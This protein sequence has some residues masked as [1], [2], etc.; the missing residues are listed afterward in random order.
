MPPVRME[1]FSPLDLGD[2]LRRMSAGG[3]QSCP[4]GGVTHGFLNVEGRLRNL[5]TPAGGSL[6]LG[7]EAEPHRRRCAT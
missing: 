7:I 1:G 3:A 4:N 5:P 6:L 2:L